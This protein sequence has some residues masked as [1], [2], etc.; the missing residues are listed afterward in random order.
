MQPRI[1][2]LNKSGNPVQWATWQDAV[3]LQAKGSIAWS[4]GEYAFDFHGG[5]SR[6]TGKQSIVTVP[7]IVAVDSNFKLRLRVP[8]LTNRNLFRRDLNICAYCGKE[9][10]D[11]ELTRDHILATS[12]G[13]EDKWSNVVTACFCCNNIKDNKTLAEAKMQLI[14]IPYVPDRAEALILQNRNILV[15][16]MDFLKAFIPKN[17]RVHLI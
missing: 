6:K 11:K 17:S 9:F 14:Y 2:T 3:T 7:S 5:K 1:L 4:L 8:S 15:D 10:K 12:R 13:G 16:Q